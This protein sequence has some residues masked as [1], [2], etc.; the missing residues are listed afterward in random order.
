MY[1]GLNYIIPAAIL[2]NEGGLPG[3]EA[4]PEEAVVW[5]RRCVELHRHITATY[6]LAVAYYTGEGCPENPDNAVRLFKQ[7]A[8]LGH[9]GAAYML[10]ECLLDGIGLERDR[11]TALEWLVTAAELGH[12]LARERVVILLNEDYERMDAGTE[13]AEA[14]KW[15]AQQDK[16]ISTTLER[17]FTL[18]SVSGEVG[19]RRTKVLESRNA[20]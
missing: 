3:I 19:R 2:L 10:G 8:H 5:W 1:S 6:E 15:A 12:G 7:A 9:A 20:D 17:R 16:G 14:K 18:G 13:E 11:G 4:C